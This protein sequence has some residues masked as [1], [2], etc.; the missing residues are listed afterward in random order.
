[1]PKKT[2]TTRCGIMPVRVRAG[3]IWAGCVAG[4]MLA[5]AGAASAQM[6]PDISA[7]ATFV[8]DYRFR[9]VSESNRDPAVQAGI[10]LESGSFFVGAWG[11]SVADFNGATTEIDLYG[12]WRGNLGPLEAEAGITS[13]LYPGG[14][15][16]DTMEFF[17]SLTGSLGPAQATVGLNW[18]PDQGNLDG[19]SRYAYGALSVGIPLTPLTARASIGHERGSMVPDASLRTTSKTDW[20]LGVDAIV[21]PLTLGVAYVGN[22][23]PEKRHFN[24]AAKNA[25]VVSLGAVF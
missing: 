1:M 11:S 4:A 12:G 2:M 17:G 3:R 21:G 18:A 15:D 25:F 10:E 16:T 7:S 8:T 24:Q 23:L 19:S 22:D 9:G 14:R 13:Y 5:S 6:I 20:M